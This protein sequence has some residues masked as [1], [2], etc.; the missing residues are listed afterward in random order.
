MALLAAGLLG[1]C[2]LTQTVEKPGHTLRSEKLRSLM[3][4]IN[5][6]VHERYQSELERDDAKRRYAFRLS[7]ALN[8]MSERIRTVPIK[9][10]SFKEQEEVQV[11]FEK[12]SRRLNSHAKEIAHIAQSF[13]IEKLNPAIRQMVNT[14]ISCHD[15]YIPGQD[16]IR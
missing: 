15:R 6:V 10:S 12:Y 13:E 14:C 8:E 11:E 4:E 2:S 9:T 7:D 16:P 5:V 3:M 1:G